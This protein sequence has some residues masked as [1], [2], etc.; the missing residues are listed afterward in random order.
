LLGTY[1][2]NRDFIKVKIK[3]KNIYLDIERA[4]PCCLIINELVTNSLKYAFPGGKGDLSIEMCRKDHK[5]MLK[6]KDS[7]TGLPDDLDLENIKT[8]GLELVFNLS[9][10][11]EGTVEIL[12]DRGTTFNII[13]PSQ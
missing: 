11:I 8:L 9:E 6:V 5:Y 7:G 10:Q 4:I 3:I 12:R 2:I 1:N 13:F